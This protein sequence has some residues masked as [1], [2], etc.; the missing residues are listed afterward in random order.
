MWRRSAAG[1]LGSGD[2][3]GDSLVYSWFFYR[4]P[5]SY[6]GSVDVQDSSSEF[7]TAFV[8]SVA[9]GQTMHMILEMHEAGLPNLYTYRRV[10]I[11]VQ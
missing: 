1:A 8:P 6:R 5:S 4:E 3:D 10:I 2:P 11:H 9:C 7:A